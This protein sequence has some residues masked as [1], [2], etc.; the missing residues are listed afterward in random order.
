MER[1]VALGIPS[2]MAR[3]GASSFFIGALV[4]EL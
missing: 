4:K 1:R 2:A 3:M